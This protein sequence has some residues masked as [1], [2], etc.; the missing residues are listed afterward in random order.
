MVENY[1]VPFN[2]KEIKKSNNFRNFKDN[3]QELNKVIFFLNNMPDK[4]HSIIFNNYTNVCPTYYDITILL[5]QKNNICNLMHNLEDIDKYLEDQGIRYIYIRI[6]ILGE[7]KMNHVNCIIIDKQEKYLLLF[8]PKFNLYYDVRVLFNF[9]DG[10]FYG[11]H[12][13]KISAADLGY[14]NFNRLQSY[15]RFCQTYVIF[16]YLLIILNPHVKYKNYKTM[17][18]NIIT[19]ENLGYLLFTIYQLLHQNNY[20]INEQPLI[21]SYPTNTFRNL[22]K[23]FKFDFLNIYSSDHLNLYEDEDDDVV[24]IDL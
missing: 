8:E 24:I 13:K 6:N 15:D 2:I 17:F 20:T 10:I 23:L 21:W 16:V 5:D 3:E 11:Y 12:Y 9:I 22:I 18:N 14:H 4:V 7:V 1:K 19:K